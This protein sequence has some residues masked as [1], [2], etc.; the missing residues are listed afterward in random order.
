M[1]PRELV[2]L[3]AYCNTFQRPKT[4][5]S[6]TQDNDHFEGERGYMAKRKLVQR[7][8]QAWH[9][10]T[11]NLVSI[12]TSA[13][14]WL[15]QYLIGIPCTRG[16]RFQVPCCLLSQ[17]ESSESE[18]ATRKKLSE[19]QKKMTPRL[20]RPAN[21]NCLLNPQLDDILTLLQCRIQRYPIKLLDAVVLCFLTSSS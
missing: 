20:K 15:L 1:P 7:R 13:M 12:K 18:F 9:H 19:K 14:D 21:K 17:L 8:H 16:F 2:A 10:A 4:N 5:W 3:G 11:A 6:S